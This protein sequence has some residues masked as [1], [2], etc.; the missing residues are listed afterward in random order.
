[1][2]DRHEKKR[3][4]NKLVEVTGFHRKHAVQLLKRSGANQWRPALETIF[5]MRR[6]DGR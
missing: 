2:R 3:A 6:C 4:F 1:V 5:T